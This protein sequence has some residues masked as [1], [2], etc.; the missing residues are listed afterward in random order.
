MKDLVMQV[1]KKVKE[2]NKM[3]VEFL[4]ETRMEVQRAEIKAKGNRNLF[5]MMG[6]LMRMEIFRWVLL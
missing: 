1:E 2:E 4:V 6:R 5:Y 3:K